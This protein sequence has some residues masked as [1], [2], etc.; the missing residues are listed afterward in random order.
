MIK[1]QY[2]WGTYTYSCINKCDHIEG[3]KKKYPTGSKR[4][5]DLYRYCGWCEVYLPKNHPEVGIYC[6]C[7]NRRLRTK[8]SNHTASRKAMRVYID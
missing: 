1:R 7:C 5:Y 6:P 2:R 4:A 3:A 8:P